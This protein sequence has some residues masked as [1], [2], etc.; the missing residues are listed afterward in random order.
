M[1]ADHLPYYKVSSIDVRPAR[2]ANASRVSENLKWLPFI[3]F[4]FAFTDFFIPS[5]NTVALK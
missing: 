1:A 2:S 3:T 4:L 5:L